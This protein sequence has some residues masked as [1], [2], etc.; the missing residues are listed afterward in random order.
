MPASERLS[1]D[2]DSRSKPLR[3]N[4]QWEKQCTLENVLLS[5]MLHSKLLTILDAYTN[6][7]VPG[8]A[9]NSGVEAV[10]QDV[11]PGASPV[12]HWGTIMVGSRMLRAEAHCRLLPRHPGT[13][14]AVSPHLDTETVPKGQAKMNVGAARPEA[15]Y[16]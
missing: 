9:R 1:G 11:G 15:A 14:T 3:N 6:T 2:T 16:V 10:P 13:A 12:P 5:G 7:A 8:L 4:L